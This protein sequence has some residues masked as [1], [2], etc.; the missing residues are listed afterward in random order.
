MAQEAGKPPLP[1]PFDPVFTLHPG[2]QPGPCMA[3]GPLRGAASDAPTSQGPLCGAHL[4]RT[5]RARAMAVIQ[6]GPCASVPRPTLPTGGLGAWNAP[7]GAWSQAS[8]RVTSRRQEHKSQIQVIWVKKRANE[9]LG[10]ARGARLHLLHLLPGVP[11]PGEPSHPALGRVGISM[12][13]GGGRG[14]NLR[15]SGGR[16]RDTRLPSIT[17]AV[18]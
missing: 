2:G 4:G 8:G 5:H 18:A 6:G 15:G 10:S 9:S 12:D 16:G 11:A 14:H 7:R 3:G 1:L 13:T 17:E